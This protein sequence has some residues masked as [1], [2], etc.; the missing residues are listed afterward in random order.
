MYKEMSIENNTINYNSIRSGNNVSIHPTAI[1]DPN[2]KIGNNV[3]IGAFCIIGKD[4]VIGDNCEIKPHVVIE[5]NTTIGKGNK[6]F[7]FAVIGEEPQDLKYERENSKVIIGDNNSIREHCTIHKGTKGDHMVTKIGNNNLLMVNTHIAHD[8]VI[9]NNCIFANNTTLGG[10]V[11]IGNYVVIGGMSAVHQKVRIGKHAMIGGMTG[12]EKDVIPYGVVV[13][14]RK[15]SL[16][17]IN[18]IGLKR[19]NFTKKQMT[20]L[21]HFYKDVFC[22]ESAS[23]FDLIEQLKEKYSESK[24]VND[25]IKFITSD[26]KRHITVKTN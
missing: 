14:P 9:G 6:I 24:V 18:L 23:I 19:R 5:G 17:G 1:V 25:I 3:K 12:V 13:E 26:S 10:H 4:V 22:V 7:S 15:T 21:R 16:E 8:C 2:A 11:H 20:E